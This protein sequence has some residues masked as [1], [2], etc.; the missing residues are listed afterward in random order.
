MSDQINS[1]AQAPR[2]AFVA[3]CK[4]ASEND[5][6]WNISCTTCGHCGFKVGFSKIIHE[7][8]PDD[9]SFWTQGKRDSDLLKEVEEYGDFWHRA[10]R[11]NQMELASIVATVKISDIQAVSKFPDWL[12]YIGLVIHHC[13]E[14]AAR[15]IIS[16]S[17]LPQFI[18]MLK[19]DIEICDYFNKKLANRELLS[20]N[21][22]SRIESGKVGLLHPPLP[23][24]TDLL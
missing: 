19:D 18:E 3:L 4:A 13:P 14:R 23:L 6:C 10:S 17:L 21:D 12:G 2:N 11:E 20:V 24:I 22:L 15:E 9:D 1:S 5:W 8:H 16:D 7:Q